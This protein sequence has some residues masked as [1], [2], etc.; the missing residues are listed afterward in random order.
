M[1]RIISIFAAIVILSMI[2]FI[3]N[4]HAAALNTIDI[5]PSKT[6]V[7]PGEE[8]TL[9]INFGQDLGAY[10]FNI[11]YDNSIFD[12]VSVEGGTANNVNDKVKVT[13]Y[14]Q[15]GGTNPRN[16]MS[17]TFRAKADITTS[18]PTEFT[19]TAEGLAN[20]DASV[21]FDDITVPI[22]KNVT[23]EPQYID[24]TIKLEHS[25]DIVKEKEKAMTLSYSSPMGHYYEHAR[26]IAEVVVPQGATVKLLA[27]DQSN[28]EHDIIQSG[29]GDAQGSKIGGKDVSQ[30]LQTRATFSQEGNYAITLKLIDR[31]NSDKVIAEKTFNLSVLGNETPANPDNQDKTPGQTTNDKENTPNKT[32]VTTNNQKEIADKTP[33]KLPKTGS[34]IYIPIVIILIVLISGYAYFNKKNK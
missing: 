26:L 2:V 10:T 9:N 7:R 18:N 20:P 32:E 17:A 1:K 23:V 14:D 12:Y 16:N 33:K 24:Y 15:T 30:V 21:Q 31:D 28:M 29:W 34:N 6:T 3:P 5:K 25:G 11:D 27:N 19:V 13:F 4:S 8:V 22:V